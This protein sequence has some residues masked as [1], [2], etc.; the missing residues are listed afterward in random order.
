[1]P[2]TPELEELIKIVESTRAAM[3]AATAASEVGT[4]LAGR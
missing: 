1:M 4:T 2:Y 3:S